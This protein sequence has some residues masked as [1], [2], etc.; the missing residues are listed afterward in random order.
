[1]KKEIALRWAAALKSKK[2]KQGAGRL[3][4][5]HD[6]F[7]C[8]GVLC[9]LHAQDHPGVARK[10]TNK[11][12]YLGSTTDLPDAVC[13]WAGTVSHFCGDVRIGKVTA[14][15]ANDVLKLPFDKIAD[16]ILKHWETI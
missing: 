2:Y 11:E 3:R 9:N 1:M 14:I 8:L 10:Q 6:D 13:K 12:E 4:S 7:C 5:A 16:R 15:R